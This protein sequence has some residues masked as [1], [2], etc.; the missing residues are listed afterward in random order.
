MQNG[1]V[2][3]VS[4]VTEKFSQLAARLR[5]LLRKSAVIEQLSFDANT[6]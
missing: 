1:S 6:Q 4:L 5:G 2:E 3:L